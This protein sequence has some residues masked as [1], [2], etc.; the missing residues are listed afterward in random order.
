MLAG[1][2]SVDTAN[3][4][5]MVRI[6][7]LHN[8]MVLTDVTEGQKSWLY[9]NCLGFLLPSWTEGF[10]LTVIEAMRH[11]KP[12]FLSNLTCLPEIGGAHAFYWHEFSAGHMRGVIDAGLAE[13]QRPDFAE[14]VRSHAAS[15]TWERCCTGYLDYYRA[16]L[17]LAGRDQTAELSSPSSRRYS[18]R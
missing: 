12:V 8:V 16:Q 18:L 1:P 14:Q 11:G 2:S 13:A 10:G 3:I 9:Q 4:R 6:R 7:G 5:N 17:G 15:F